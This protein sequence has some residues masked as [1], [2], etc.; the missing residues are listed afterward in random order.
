MTGP[1]IT[2]AILELRPAIAGLKLPDH[3]SREHAHP[4]AAHRLDVGNMLRFRDEHGRNVQHRAPDTGAPRDKATTAK[5]RLRP[6]RLACRL[7]V[8]TAAHLVV[9]CRRRMS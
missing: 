8:Q 4:H 5:P 2:T 7:E 9:T 6:N 1:S 3:W